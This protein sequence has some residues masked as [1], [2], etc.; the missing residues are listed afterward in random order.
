VKGRKNMPNLTI[1][2][3]ETSI[4][5]EKCYTRAKL[6]FNDLYEKICELYLLNK[7]S[8]DGRREF[9]DETFYSIMNRR[10]RA[11]CDDADALHEEFITNVFD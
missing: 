11:L 5:Y 3:N 6:E 4:D 7:T 9:D 2:T 8:N 10:C 1:K